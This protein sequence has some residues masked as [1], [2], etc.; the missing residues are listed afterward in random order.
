M[1]TPAPHTL[2]YDGHCALCHGAVTFTVKRDRDARFRF[3]PLGGETFREQFPDAEAQDV[4]DSIIVRTADG[5]TYA[6]SSATVFVLKELGGGWTI[7]AWMLWAVPR[8]VRDLGYRAVAA[9]RYRLFGKK[10]DVCPLMPK[11]LRGRFGP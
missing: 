11:E 4:P 8:P 10:D 5:R 1:P 6:R 2:F 7:L 9:V 3:A